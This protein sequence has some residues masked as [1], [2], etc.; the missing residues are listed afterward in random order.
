VGP[1]QCSCF[2]MFL[3]GSF[4]GESQSV[5]FVFLHLWFA[6]AVGSVVF[7]VGASRHR[8]NPQ[9]LDARPRLARWTHLGVLLG[10][11]LFYGGVSPPVL[12]K[13]CFSLA[14]R[15]EINTS[16]G[17]PLGHLSF[18][19]F[20]HCWPGG[21]TVGWFLPFPLWSRL[22]SFALDVH[23]GNRFPSTLFFAGRIVRL[24][25][26]CFTP[27][28]VRASVKET[29]SPSFIFLTRSNGGRWT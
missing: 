13:V 14:R 16:A 7:L 1:V 27:S 8:T 12:G 24:G 11:A 3:S 26:S 6:G 29:E 17:F 10:F 23:D 25:G 22:F 21:R 20:L 28:V 4:P 9:E 19:C 5:L 18:C 15:N 2:W